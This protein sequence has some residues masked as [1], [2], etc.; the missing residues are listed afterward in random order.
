MKTIQIKRV[1][2]D[3]S[4]DDGYRVFVDRLWP[5]GVSK[6][7]AHFDEWIKE[8]APSTELRKWFNHKPERFDEFSKRYRKE[9]K[10]QDEKLDELRDIAKTKKVTLLYAAKDI[11][12][13]NAVVIR[14]VLKGKG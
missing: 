1:Y 9:L 4:D 2:D 14:D 12:I 10:E 3:K 6:E 5:R 8:L 7:D 11:E 13:N